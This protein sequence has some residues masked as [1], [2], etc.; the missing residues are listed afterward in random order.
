MKF[1]TKSIAVKQAMTQEQAVYR[2]YWVNYGDKFDTDL[3]DVSGDTTGPVDLCTF[4]GLERVI[5][6]D[7]VTSVIPVVKA[8]AV[9]QI[10]DAKK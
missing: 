7:G 6:K 3:I 1:V 5:K 8:W 4:P 2:C 10:A 9:L